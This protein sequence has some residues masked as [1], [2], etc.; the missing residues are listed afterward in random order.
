[1][2]SD[3][4]VSKRPDLSARAVNTEMAANAN[5]PTQLF[6]AIRTTPAVGCKRY[7]TLN[8][9]GATMGTADTTP[10]CCGSCCAGWAS[11]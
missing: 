6:D 10:N 7:Q 11:R 9:P 4:D 5:N 8:C 3:G 1:M 2:G